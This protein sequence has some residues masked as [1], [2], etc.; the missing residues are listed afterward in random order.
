MDHPTSISAELPPA[1]RCAPE[2]M[3]ISEAQLERVAAA[4]GATPPVTHAAAH[5]YPA[6]APAYEPSPCEQRVRPE[7]RELRL[8]VHIPFCNYKC[9]FCYYATR[10]GDTRAEQERYVAALERELA[11]V[12]P[13]ATL[14]QL[15][16]G[17]GTPT[18]LPAELLDR[19]LASVFAALPPT[20]EHGHTVEASPES[21]K[22]AHVDV[23]RQRGVHR[24]S[25]G[26]QSLDPRILDGVQRRHD[27]KQVMTAVELIVGSGLILNVD[28]M[29]GLPSQSEDSFRRDLETLAECGA[30]SVTLYDLRV[31]NRTPLGRSLR[32]DERLD[33]LHLLRWRSF[34]RSL[35]AELG[36]TQTRW[37]TFKRLG[38]IAARHER[39]ACFDADMQGYQLGI[40]MSARSHLRTTIYRNHDRIGEYVR[41]VEAGKSPVEEVFRLGAEDLRTQFIAR[42]LGD[43]KRLE[44][45]AYE[46]AFGRPID[47][48]YGAVLGRLI[49]A[50]LV[51]EG[52]AQLALTDLGRL[53]YDRVLLQFYPKHAIEWLWAQAA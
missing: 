29:Y 6:A 35:T 15:F 7:T 11:W 2:A 49:A 1:P 42:S 48:D 26:V 21:I 12:E 17:G 18:A 9:N 50:G 8:Y 47:G 45:S 32:E 5:V 34:V 3:P 4:L 37:H 43:G 46:R 30:H 53:V 28:L 38:S 25:M 14:S 44:R 33:L 31:T 20:R 23:L 51:E 13:G 27:R 40:G 24:V 52:G 36:F 22:R 19:T 41:R 10:V 39:V 16:V